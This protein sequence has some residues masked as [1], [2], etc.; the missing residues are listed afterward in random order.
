MAD[1]Y[2]QGW[3]DTYDDVVSEALLSVLGPV[4][5]LAVLDVACGHGRYT[6]AIARR[7]GSPVVGPDLSRELIERALAVEHDRP[8]GIRYVC[9]DLARSVELSDES[10]DRVVC[11]FGLS[12]VD[13]MDE[14]I[15]NVARMLRVGGRFV[16]SIL[17]PCFPGVQDVAGSWPEAGRYYDELRWCADSAASTLRQRVG[18]NHRTISTYV[19]CLVRHGLAVDRVIEPEP[20]TEWAAE[21][22]TAARL[23]LYL[24]VGS[25]KV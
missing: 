8:L 22:P 2:V 9:D 14:A 3:P 23:P 25:T 19:N 21:R 24:V 1:F 11:G 5:D 7:G 17:H 16:F 4:E 15:A 12:D 18:A 10:F 13:D 20:S 6:R